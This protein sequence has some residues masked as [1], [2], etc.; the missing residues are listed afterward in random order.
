MSAIAERT[1]AAQ[2]GRRLLLTIAATTV[3]AACGRAGTARTF[4]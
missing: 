4:R 1:T 3:L 2:S